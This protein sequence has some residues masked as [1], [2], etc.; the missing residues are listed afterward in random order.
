MS[1]DE[2]LTMVQEACFRYYWEGAETTSGLAKENIPGRTNM[3]ASGASGFGLMALLVGI[4]RKFITREEG[5][6]RF[7]KI[8]NFLQKAESFHG[9]FSHFIDG[10][11]G[12]VKPS[13]DGATTAAIW[14]KPRSSYRVS[15]PPGHTS[16]KTMRRK[17]NFGQA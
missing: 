6:A 7:E 9:A 10:P 2:L 16:P 5:I 13:L 12:K 4:E 3:I 14:L 1:D 15:S 17:I 11:T 8:I